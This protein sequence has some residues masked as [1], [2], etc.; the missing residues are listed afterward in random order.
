[1]KNIFRLITICLLFCSIP[2]VTGAVSGAEVMKEQQGR[3]ADFWRREVVFGAFSGIGGVRLQYAR[4]AVAGQTALV[5]VSGRTEFME[6]YAEVCHD[7]RDAGVSFYIYDHRGQGS[8]ERLLADSQKGHV[9]SFANYVG[10]LKIFI[11]TVVRPDRPRKIILLSHSMGGTI[12]LLYA[13]EHQD[14]LGGLILSSPMF[15]ITTRPIPGF[16]ARIISRAAVLVGRKTD[17]VFGTGPYKPDIPF[18][19]NDLT[20]SSSRFARNLQLIEENPAL[21]LGGPTFGWLDQS[22]TAVAELQKM[23]INLQLPVLL[24]QGEADRVVG[25]RE[26]QEICDRLADCRRIA[27]PGG[28]HEL[29]MEEDGL[30]AAVLQE[31][32]TFVKEIGR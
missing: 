19:D 4:R 18:A 12:S 25:R 23:R 15:S 30:R 9:E 27:F 20:G 21:A 11:D 8:S 3:V 2:A 7:L 31:I 14:L 13:M 29:M 26:Q 10:D 28:R 22:F 32:R 5:V 1:M 6:K 17:Y 16:L 24:L